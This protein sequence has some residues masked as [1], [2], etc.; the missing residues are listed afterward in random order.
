MLKFVPYA[1]WSSFGIKGLLGVDELNSYKSITAKVYVKDESNTNVYDEDTYVV[2]A[3]RYHLEDGSYEEVVSVP[4]RVT[5]SWV[6]IQ[7]SLGSYNQ[8]ALSSRDFD[9]S[10]FKIVDGQ[11]VSTGN[12]NKEVTVY[13]DDIYAK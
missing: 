6:N 12:Y 11:P 1:E 9:I 3:L 5:E 7:M 2:V 8:Y 13:L 10:I 4:V